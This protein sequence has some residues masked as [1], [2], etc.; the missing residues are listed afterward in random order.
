MVITLRYKKKR[1]KLKGYPIEHY[2]DY[3]LLVADMDQLPIGRI[4][5][6]KKAHAD[7]PLN[8]RLD[9]HLQSSLAQQKNGHC[10]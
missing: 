4:N 1:D 6:F 5:T 8:H 10:F 3:A 7:S 2:L 9:R